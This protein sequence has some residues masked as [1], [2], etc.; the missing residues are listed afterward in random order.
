MI[1]D[2]IHSINPLSHLSNLSNL[3]N[4]SSPTLHTAKRAGMTGIP[5]MDGYGS[6]FRIWVTISLISRHLDSIADDTYHDDDDWIEWNRM[7]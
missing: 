7:G 6:Y 3:S 1:W 4:L 2:K 5:R